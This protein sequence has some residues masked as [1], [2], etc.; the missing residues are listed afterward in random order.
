MAWRR[1]WWPLLTLRT[2]HVCPL[3]LCPLHLCP[4]VWELETQHCIQTC[5]GHRCEVWAMDVSPDET[6]VVTGGSDSQLRLWRVLDTPSLA[7]ADRSVAGS[8]KSKRVK[9]TAD[10]TVAT[11]A[12][13]ADTVEPGGDAA[14]GDV[15]NDATVRYHCRDVQSWT[16]P[17]RPHGCRW[18]QCCHCVPGSGVLYDVGGVQVLELIGAVPSL[19]RERT[20]GVAFSRDG[21]FV[22]VV[23]A[24]KGMEVFRVRNDDEVKRRIARRKRRQREKQRERAEKQVR[25]LGVRHLTSLCAAVAVDQACQ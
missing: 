13:A 19:R 24:G 21:L 10:G 23:A 2:L 16:V 22:G 12:T 9:V 25:G 8:S 7:A 11:T 20:S 3:H 18:S 6:R 17:Q 1:S 5:V 15:V 14:V 4:Q